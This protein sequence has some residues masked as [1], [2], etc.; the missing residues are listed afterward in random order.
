EVKK[1]MNSFFRYKQYIRPRLSEKYGKMSN[2]E[3]SKRITYCWKNETPEIKKY[4]RDLA[5][6]SFEEHKLKYPDF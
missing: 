4:F 2:G 5:K 6:K 3:M 1:P